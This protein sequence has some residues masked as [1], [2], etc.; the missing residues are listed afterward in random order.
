MIAKAAMTNPATGSSQVQPK[1]AK[2]SRPA[3]VDTDSQAHSLVSAASATTRRE[4]ISSPALRLAR[5]SHGMITMDTPVRAMPT[6]E[7]SGFSPLTRS[8]MPS[9]ITY[10]ASAKNVT[11][12]NF[13][14]R[15]SLASSGS[16]PLI[17][18]SR[19]TRTTTAA[20]T[21][22]P[23]STPKPI[24]ETAPATVPAAMAMIPSMML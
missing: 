17:S 12:M 4:F 18:A 10:A 24:R 15:R 9:T 23:E 2:A 11:A 14:A 16:P 5:A 20:A 7:A 8:R 1:T 3:K 21:S 22:M 6:R 19:R 13:S